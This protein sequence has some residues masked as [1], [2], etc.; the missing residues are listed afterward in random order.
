MLADTVGL[1]QPLGVKLDRP[2]INRDKTKI[3]AN[4]VLVSGARAHAPGDELFSK[5]LFMLLY[6]KF[7]FFIL[8]TAL[9]PFGRVLESALLKGYLGGA[10][11]LSWHLSLLLQHVHMLC[12]HWGFNQQPS[13]NPSKQVLGEGPDKGQPPPTPY[14]H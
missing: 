11:K 14:D 2:L 3:F 4:A 8:L 7:T 12:A 6:Y 9:A 5:M 13:E 1:H 10:L